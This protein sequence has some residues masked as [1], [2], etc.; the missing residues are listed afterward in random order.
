MTKSPGDSVDGA[1]NRSFT[2]ARAD[3][4]YRK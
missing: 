4:V 2:R 1:K 3:R